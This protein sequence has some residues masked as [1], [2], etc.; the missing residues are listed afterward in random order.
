MSS[1]YPDSLDIFT[2]LVN[3]YD[4]PTANWWNQLFSAIYNIEV[5]LGTD[6]SDLG[7][8]FGSFTSIA[9]VLSN[10]AKVE[11]GEFELE[12]PAN[13]PTRVL[14]ASGEDRWDVGNDMIV[15]CNMK[16]NKTGRKVSPLAR[17][18]ARVVLGPGGDPYGFDFYRTDMDNASGTIE[19]RTEVWSYLAIEENM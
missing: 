6:P 8:G 12:I 16:L 1:V 19:G 17:H 7:T 14:F 5:A 13:D 4:K 18:T 2:R 15:L 3:E 11:A 9:D 10:F